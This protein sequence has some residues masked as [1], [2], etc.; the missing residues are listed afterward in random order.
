MENWNYSR[1]KTFWKIYAIGIF[2]GFHCIPEKHFSKSTVWI[3]IPTTLIDRIHENNN[4][5]RSC[6]NLYVNRYA[7]GFFEWKHLI[8]HVD[9]GFYGSCKTNNKSFSPVSRKKLLFFILSFLFPNH[10]VTVDI[11]LLIL[12]NLPMY[13]LIW[14]SEAAYIP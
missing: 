10:A 13:L 6:E 8:C 3:I 11:L 1:G 14:V 12:D 4:S 9:G 2:R 5:M 7:K